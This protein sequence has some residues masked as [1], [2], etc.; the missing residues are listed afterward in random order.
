[1]FT[2]AS[3]E[4]LPFLR[5]ANAYVYVHSPS[6]ACI[7]THTSLFRCSI[8]HLFNLPVH[9]ASLPLGDGKSVNKQYQ[10]QLIHPSTKTPFS[11]HP[12]P[13]VQGPVGRDLGIPVP[14]IITQLRQ[15][16]PD[17]RDLTATRGV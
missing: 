16:H 12:L 2:S 3:K 6:A 5:N 4:E 13:K 10:L 17:E 15:S 8:E 7:H 9:T 11:S 14:E 1:V